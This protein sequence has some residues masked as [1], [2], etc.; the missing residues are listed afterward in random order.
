MCC[1]GDRT[2]PTIWSSSSCAPRGS[3]CASSPR[4]QWSS[5]VF[6]RPRTCITTCWTRSSMPP[7]GSASKCEGNPHP[8]SPQLPN[9]RA[10]D[11][12]FSSQVLWHH[13]PGTDPKQVLSW[14]QYHRPG[15]A[16][17]V[18]CELIK[19]NLNTSSPLSAYSSNPGVFDKVHAAL[20]LC[21]RCHFLHHSILFNC[22][23]PSGCGLLL[24]PE[25][26]PGGLQVSEFIRVVLKT[27]NLFTF[28]V[29]FPPSE[30][31]RTSTTPH[32]FLC[33]VT[34]LR[35]LRVLPP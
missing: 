31:F 19:A 6:L 3:L 2:T 13:P 23:L 32:S 27:C 17:P 18:S 34:S 28:V 11:E 29:C 22:P 20:S 1:Y 30:T 16:N 24:H 10:F 5:W 33:S 4:S 15:T 9:F 35:R 26:L 12:L 8:A 25:V 7:S 14:Y 21:H